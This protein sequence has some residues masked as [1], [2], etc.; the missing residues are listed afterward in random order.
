MDKA[1]TQITFRHMAHSPAFDAYARQ[2][3]LKLD[4]FLES[5]RPPITIELVIEALPVHAHSRVEIIVKTA[6]LYLV[7]H[8]EGPDLYAVIDSAVT[9]MGRELNKAKEKFLDKRKDS[10]KRQI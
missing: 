7:S 3:L 2:E 10:A 6:R 8:D 5:E 9:T 4:K 1:T